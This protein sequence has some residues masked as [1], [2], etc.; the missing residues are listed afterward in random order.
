L[1]QSPP[2]KTGVFPLQS[3]NRPPLTTQVE[4]DS[5]KRVLE[6]MKK[7][8]AESEAESDSLRGRTTFLKLLLKEAKRDLAEQKQ[9]LENALAKNSDLENTLLTQSSQLKELSETGA[10]GEI[11]RAELK[12]AKNQ[13]ERLKQRLEKYLDLLSM[14]EKQLATFKEY[15]LRFQ[16]AQ[17]TIKVLET[18]YKAASEELAI[19]KERQYTQDVSIE[20][21][22]KHGEQLERAI[23]F[24]RERNEEAQLESRNLEEELVIAQSTLDE[25]KK[26]FK[27]IQDEAISLKSALSESEETLNA[28]HAEID[29]LK[30]EK[31]RLFRQNQSLQTEVDEFKNRLDHK[32]NEIERLKKEMNEKARDCELKAMQIEDLVRRLSTHESVIA[33]KEKEISETL[34]AFSEADEETKALAQQFSE[35][36]RLIAERESERNEL[37]VQLDEMKALELTLRETITRFE[38]DNRELV[39]EKKVLEEEL[40]ELGRK[41]EESESKAQLAKQHLGKKVK[42]STLLSE[43]LEK[44]TKEHNEI[45]MQLKEAQNRLSLLQKNQEMHFIEKQQFEGKIRETALIGEAKAR[46]L[47]ERCTKLQQSLERVEEENRNLRQQKE[48]FDQLQNLLTNLGPSSMPPPQAIQEEALPPPPQSTEPDKATPYK[49]LFDYNQH[50]P[51]TKSNFFD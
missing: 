50:K 19:Y 31:E 35:L 36:K 5:L 46:D 33:E 34:E 4:D 38:T 37:K 15:Q 28:K 24:L 9:R 29:D 20:E 1:A 21:K 30:D 48:K 39:H 11:A 49:N 23:Q 8:L 27:I 10:S 26:Q 43:T 18:D 51:K 47:E 44:N 13:E 45:H 42:E 3:E 17:E 14:R 41:H 2:S 25:T 40:K 32:Q 7:K 22:K 12:E 16:K 6:R